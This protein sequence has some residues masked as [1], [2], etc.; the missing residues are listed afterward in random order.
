[1][2]ERRLSVTN[3]V[4]GRTTTTTDPN[5]YFT[6]GLLSAADACLSRF[7]G[8]PPIDY[9]G[10]MASRLLPTPLASPHHLMSPGTS[11]SPAKPPQLHPHHYRVDPNP[12]VL[13]NHFGSTQAFL[14]TLWANPNMANGANYNHL[15]TP[16]KPP[17]TVCSTQF[18]GDGRTFFPQSSQPQPGCL[19]AASVQNHLDASQHQ[20]VQLGQSQQQHKIMGDMSRLPTELSSTNSSATNVDVRSMPQSCERSPLVRSANSQSSSSV[21]SPLNMRSSSGTPAALN[22]SNESVSNHQY[23]NYQSPH[24]NSQQSSP[25][26]VR[27][28]S[29]MSN[30]EQSDTVKS[31]CNAGGFNPLAQFQPSSVGS[32]PPSMM[33]SSQLNQR[34]QQRP[35]QNF[36]SSSSSGGFYS[37][38]VSIQRERDMSVNIGEFIC[39]SESE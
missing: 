29:S 38:K 32:G 18:L 2:D 14:Q 27:T 8:I 15:Q 39:V 21:A 12:Q 25:A 30:A 13:L 7:P 28:H 26:T 10:A 17:E 6:S 34:S 33:F 19:P 37:F 16:L 11:W 9:S 24:G 36:P 1:M 5:F 20:Y 23:H 3:N 31:G 22:Q 4:G 35:T